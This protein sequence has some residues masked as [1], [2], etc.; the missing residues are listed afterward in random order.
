ML[1]AVDDG[2]TEN[3]DVK[4]ALE[5]PDREVVAG[6]WLYEATMGPSERVTAD[7]V[8]IVAVSVTAVSM[9]GVE[10][11]TLVRNER[12]TSTCIDLVIVAIM[13]LGNNK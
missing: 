10:R 12:T 9:A 4:V 11:A 7:G 3:V 5:Y 2:E 13:L 8:W 6:L 1:T